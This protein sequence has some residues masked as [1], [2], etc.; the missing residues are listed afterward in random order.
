MLVHGRYRTIH[1]VSLWSW[2]YPFLRRS[3]DEEYL[4]LRTYEGNIAASSEKQR[5]E[6]ASSSSRS[7]LKTH[8][9]LLLLARLRAWLMIR[10]PIPWFWHNFLPA[11]IPSFFVLSKN[12][13][14][15]QHNSL[16]Y[17]MK[18]QHAHLL[19]ILLTAKNVKHS[20]A[21][22]NMQISYVGSNR[23]FSTSQ[24]RRSFRAPNQFDDTGAS[25]NNLRTLYSSSTTSNLFSSHERRDLKKR[26]RLLT[27]IES[28]ASPDN[29]NKNTP[30]LRK[31][32]DATIGALWT[33]FVSTLVRS[34]HAVIA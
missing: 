9:Y 6:Q 33:L 29:E 28:S 10:S 21:Y 24:N 13:H 3:D 30:I 7:K 12:H 18:F 34:T 17:T 20:F 5:S 26:Q 25:R 1:A 32:Y 4:V 16:P 2:K 22:M 11:S 23:F 27:S 19:L 8:Q 14:W 31:I 15:T